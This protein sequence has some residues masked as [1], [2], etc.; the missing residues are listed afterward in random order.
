[1]TE[2]E[3]MDTL[4]ITRDED[5]ARRFTTREEAHAWIRA[6]GLKWPDAALIPCAS[7]PDTGMYNEWMIEIRAYLR[8]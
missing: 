2:P 4:A 8:A 1:M 3:K 7:D 6:H 5:E